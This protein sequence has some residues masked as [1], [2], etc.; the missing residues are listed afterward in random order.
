[1]CVPLLRLLLD[2]RLMM[3][4]VTEFKKETEEG[5]IKGETY[6]TFLLFAAFICV[7]LDKTSWWL[8][9]APLL[10]SFLAKHSSEQFVQCQTGM[11][12]DNQVLISFIENSCLM[13]VCQY[14]TSLKYK[15]QFPH[16]FSYFHF[17]CLAS[18]TL[19]V[20]PERSYLSLAGSFYNCLIFQRHFHCL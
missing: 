16:S 9:L 19:L 11:T 12:P 2:C 17:Q 10:C 13:H 4:T 14:S 3:M 15:Y 18:K 20:G 1:M 7:Y 5:D 6:Q 8:V